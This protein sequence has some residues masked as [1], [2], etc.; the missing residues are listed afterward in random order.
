MLKAVC[1]AAGLM[2]VTASAAVA[3]TP[4]SRTIALSGVD[5]RNPA[6][7]RDLYAKLKTAANAVCDSYAAN[8]RVSAADVACTHQVLGEAVRKVDRPVLTAMYDDG[9]ATRMASNPD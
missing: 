7:V 2:A 1:I 8:G 6:A 3:E 5:F 4:Q 9:A